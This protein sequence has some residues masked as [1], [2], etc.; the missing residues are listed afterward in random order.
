MYSQKELKAMTVKELKA[1]ADENKINYKKSIKKADLIDLIL[2]SLKVNDV[3]EKKQEEFHKA[4]ASSVSYQDDSS[5]TNLN[6]YEDIPELPLFYGK[7]KMVFMVRDPYW[8]FV[9]WE[10]SDK[11]TEYH[12][13]HNPVLDKYLRVYNIS[14]SGNPATAGSFFDIKI[15]GVAN[16]WYINFQEPNNTFVVDIGY[17]KDGNFVTVLRSNPATTPRDGVSDQID[18]EWM[19]SDD[20]FKF[21][22]NAS[23][24]NALFQHDGSQELMKF[25]AGN[26]SENVSSGMSSLSSPIGPYGK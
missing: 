6:Y 14:G 5:S 22:L 24:A 10:F 11:T 16:N 15:N 17:F 4:S 20:Q 3:E 23:G 7:D 8:G 9:Y 2:L 25:L 18:E 1:L 13:L 26:I 19:L 12:D 21:I